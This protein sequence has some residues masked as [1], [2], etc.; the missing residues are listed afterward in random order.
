MILIV[1]LDGLQSGSFH[2][3]CLSVS[4]TLGAF[5]F[6]I[7]LHCGGNLLEEVSE[8]KDLGVITD[9]DLKFHSR[10]ALVA[11]EAN[12]LLGLLK[13]YFVNLSS[14]TFTKLSFVQF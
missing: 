7:F 9:K 11:N 10:T 4:F 6:Y 1:V 14:T 13:H 3:M 8:E 5:E 12:R 2:L